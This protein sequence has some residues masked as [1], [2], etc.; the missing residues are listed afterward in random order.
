PHCFTNVGDGVLRIIGIHASATI[1]QT[2]LDED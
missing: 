2:F 1:I